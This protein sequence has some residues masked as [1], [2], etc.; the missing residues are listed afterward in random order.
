MPSTDGRTEGFEA[1]EFSA[2]ETPVQQAD[3][4]ETAFEVETGV[5]VTSFAPPPGLDR[6]ET[7]IDAVPGLA[8]TSAFPELDEPVEEDRGDV[9]PPHGDPIVASSPAPTAPN[10]DDSLLDLEMPVIDEPARTPH[11]EAEQTSRASGDAAASE[12]EAPTIPAE[13]PPEVI[14]A[15]AALVDEHAAS[16]AAPAEPQPSA[17]TDED[18]AGGEL[19]FIDVGETTERVEAE[20]PAVSTEPEPAVEEQPAVGHRPFVTETMAELYLKQ[21]FRTGGPVGLRTAQRRD[22]G[23]RSVVG[24]GRVAA[25]RAG[26]SD[27]GDFTGGARLLRSDRGPSAWRTCRRVRASV[28]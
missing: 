2:P 19:S 24:Q 27:A 1:T 23:R 13:L 16:A 11:A 5:H 25:C 14:A 26:G 12:S 22:A 20:A 3:G 4:L 8:T 21:G 17:P 18:S 7:T 6:P 10:R 28:R 15:E 9:L